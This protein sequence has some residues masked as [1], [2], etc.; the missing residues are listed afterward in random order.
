MGYEGRIRL[1]DD[2]R[3]GA[4][5]RAY[6]TLADVRRALMD[7]GFPVEVVSAAG[8]S[9]VM[10]AIADP[11]ITEV[12]CGV[13]ALMEPEYTDFFLTSQVGILTLSMAIFLEAVGLFW[14]WSIVRIDY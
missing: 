8:T 5:V 11:W 2:D 14:L 1:R 7:A 12:Q 13:Y 4:I 9:T 10:E 6:S 3:A